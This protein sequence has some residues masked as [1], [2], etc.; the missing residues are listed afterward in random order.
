M[1]TYKVRSPEIGDTRPGHVL[2][3]DGRVLVLQAELCA[4]EGETVLLLDDLGLPKA[5]DHALL[6]HDVNPEI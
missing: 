3:Q 1:R 6:D 4:P 5:I 2:L